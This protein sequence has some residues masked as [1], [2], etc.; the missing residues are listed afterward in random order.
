MINNYV[1]FRVADTATGYDRLSSSEADLNQLRP[2]FWSKYWLSRV[3]DARDLYSH[4]IDL[5]NDD[6]DDDPQ[7]EM[8]RSRS[9]RRNSATSTLLMA[10]KHLQLSLASA[11]LMLLVSYSRSC[12]L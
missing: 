1:I 9:P 11:V 5:N 4:R 10:K 7:R 2:A 8:L 12:W 6:P 3:P